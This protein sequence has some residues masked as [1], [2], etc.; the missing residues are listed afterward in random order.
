M[1]I[2]EDACL[3]AAAPCDERP[4]SCTT[5]ELL[6]QARRGDRNA[7]DA[8][9]ARYLPRLRR[10]AH[11]RL[12]VRARDRGDTTDIAQDAAMNVFS[13]L[14]QFEPRHRGALRAYL[15]QAVLNRIHDERR[16]V[17]RRPVSLELDDDFADV[18]ARS[19]FDEAAA[20]ETVERYRRALAQ[21]RTVE[22]QAIVAR[23]E[24]GYSYAQI[25]LM[26]DRPT[27]GAARVLVNRA[28][29][30]LADLMK[31]STPPQA[32]AAVGA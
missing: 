10:W 4:E 1:T 8:L 28:L 2:S 26:L 24:M 30:K 32:G 7:L 27:A 31:A 21:L 23:V 15:H 25:A 22:Q 3:N 18:A 29:A 20:A 5:L 13:R 12:P 17:A 19:P 11:G 14:D 6:R 16:R 9:F